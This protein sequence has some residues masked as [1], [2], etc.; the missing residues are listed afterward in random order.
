[1][2]ELT[3]AKLTMRGERTHLEFCCQ[4]GGTPVVILGAVEIAPF[5]YED[6]AEKSQSVGLVTLF[7]AIA[8]ERESLTHRADGLGM[9][10][11]EQPRL[12]TEQEVLGLT[13]RSQV[14]DRSQDSLEC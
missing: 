6:V 5:R 12:T 4:H 9:L 13:G 8:G 10:A 3:E 1:M 11:Y 7:S 2:I 14:C